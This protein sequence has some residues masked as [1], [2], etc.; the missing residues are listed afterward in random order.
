MPHSSPKARALHL[1]RN[2][3]ICQSYF[4]ICFHAYDILSRQYQ[5]NT[6]RMSTGK[7][8]TNKQKIL[9]ETISNILPTSEKID[10]LVGFFYF[11]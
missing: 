6:N 7:F 4:L 9:K 1:H 10:M 2:M 8:I 11:S 5:K 3:C